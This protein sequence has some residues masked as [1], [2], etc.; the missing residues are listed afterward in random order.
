MTASPE[1]DRPQQSTPA[2]ITLVTR[3]ITITAHVEVSGEA[4]MVVR[5]DAAAHASSTGIKPGD[6][7]E[8]FWRAG[9]EER[10]LPAQVV[11]VEDGALVHLHLRAT[12]PAERSQRR[13]AVR[14]RVELPVQVSCGATQL[15]GVTVDISEAGMR[16]DVDGWG[17]PPEPGT[18]VQVILTL[19]KGFVDLR[20]EIVRQQVHGA[21]WQLS[22][23]FA[24]IAEADQDRL[25]QRVFQALREE[26]AR[27]AD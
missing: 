11:E 5:P 21:R 4:G 1:V 14:A 2:D 6:P 19:E 18:P 23:K 27:A 13:K 25:R 10:T 9:Y 15:T 20:G 12:G 3:G 24:G 7:V 8:L 17:L 26:R 16:A 22:M